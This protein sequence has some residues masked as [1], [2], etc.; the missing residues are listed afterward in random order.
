M[1]QNHAENI[2]ITDR[3]A[4]H[5]ADNDEMK[6]FIDSQSNNGLKQ[7]YNEM[8]KGCIEHPM[9]R[10]WHAIW[11]IELH[12]G[13]HIGELCFKGIS[14][15]GVVE[16]GYGIAEEYRGQGYATEAVSA[17]VNWAMNQ[18]EVTSVEAETESDN[19]AS[20]K[21]LLKSGFIANGTVGEEGPRFV[22]KER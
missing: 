16:I 22:R 5:I 14:P 8:L 21:V 3:T 7:A 1:I 6:A 2:I 10:I 15:Q 17:V 20:Q 9:Q 19:T 13:Q 18:P 11:M 12:D 4:I